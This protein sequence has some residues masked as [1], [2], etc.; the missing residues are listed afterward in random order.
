MISQIPQNEHKPTA[1]PPA[2]APLQGA[3]LRQALDQIPVGMR[4]QE[5]FSCYLLACISLG[6]AQTAVPPLR[7]RAAEIGNHPLAAATNHLSVSLAQ[8]AVLDAAATYDQA[9]EGSSSLANA[10]TLISS[11][12][13][14]SSSGSTADREAAQRLANEIRNSVIIQKSPEIKVVQYWR[15]KWAGHRAVDPQVDP[16]AWDNPLKFSTIEAGLEQM[17]TAFHEFA[18]LLEQVPELASLQGRAQRIDDRTLRM[19]ISL[20]GTS[21]WPIEATISIG[22][23]QAQAFLDRTLPVLTR[24]PEGHPAGEPQM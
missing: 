8:K 23:A 1:A 4:L 3:G 19:G 9:G 10:I 17:R 16:W 13:R 15:N 24:D 11:H 6:F 7:H 14:S 5:A 20:E 12:L 22:A 21:F 18:L 2:L